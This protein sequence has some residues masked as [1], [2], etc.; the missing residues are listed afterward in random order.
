M[1]FRTLL[2]LLFLVG[3]ILGG[4]QVVHAADGAAGAKARMRQRVPQLDQLKLAEA[5]G[6]NNRGFVEVRK[7]EGDA[8]SVVEA[9]NRDR[10][11]VFGET[12]RNTGSSPDAVGRAFAKQIAAAS[13]RGVWVQREDGSWQKK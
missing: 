9:E 10:T 8:A 3:A 2:S 6:E 11:E 1:N 13:A 5:V 12:A 7:P 4:A